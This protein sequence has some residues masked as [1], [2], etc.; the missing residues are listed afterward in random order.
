MAI[1]SF[2]TAALLAGA[3]FMASNALA[4]GNAAQGKIKSQTCLGCHGIPGYTT[5]YPN[6]PVPKLAG[7][8]AAYIIAALK[9][10]KSGKRQFATMQAQASELSKQDMRDIAAYFSSLGQPAKS[11][12]AKGDSK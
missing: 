10:Y 8:R 7:Q 12:K 4:A 1:R 6:Y 2:G 3:A 11:A 5:V 9:D